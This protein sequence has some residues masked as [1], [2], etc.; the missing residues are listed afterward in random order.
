MNIENIICKH[1]TNHIQET[2][3][4]N[5]MGNV[6]GCIAR[7]ETLFNQISPGLIATGYTFNRR[8]DSYAF[9]VGMPNT[10]YG[11]SI[12][13]P[14]D[15][16]EHADKYGWVIETA[17][18]N[19]TTDRLIYNDQLDYYDTLRFSTV[20]ELLA[21]ITRVHAAVNVPG[22]AA[23]PAPVSPAASVDDPL[24]AASGGPVD[25]PLPAAPGGPVDVPLPAAPGGPRR[26]TP[27]EEMQLISML[28][29]AL[30]RGETTST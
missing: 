23:P 24:P 17:L 16:N 6:T 3:N 11:L 28:T 19:M 21:E 29:S 5:K 18:W 7:S 2:L 8:P 4:K 14:P 15:A 20:D 13:Y 9:R 1:A 10:S 25:D 30:R 12:S 22:F 26:M 27:V